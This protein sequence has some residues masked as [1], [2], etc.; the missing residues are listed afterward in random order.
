MPLVA[1]LGAQQHPSPASLLPA[2]GPEGMSTP[3]LASKNPNG[4][5]W[6]P[7]TSTGMT[8]RTEV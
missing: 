4:F 8:C 1:A 7:T 2:F 6:K 5:K 3:G